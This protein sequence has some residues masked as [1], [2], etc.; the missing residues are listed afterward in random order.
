MAAY[1]NT[2]SLNLLKDIVILTEN[3][4]AKF[5]KDPEINMVEQ[6]VKTETPR[7]KTK[8]ETK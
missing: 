7:P 2:L 3:D 5:E 4:V 8:Q 6:L 1:L